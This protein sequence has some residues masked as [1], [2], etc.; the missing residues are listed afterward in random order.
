MNILLV[1]DKKDVLDTMGELLEVCQNHKVQGV[2]SGKEAIRF[3]RKKRYDLV[4]MD[5]MLP[6]MN[7]VEVIS[8]VRKLRSELRIVVLTGIPLNEDLKEKLSKLDVHRIFVK[9]K[10]IHDL[11]LYIKDFNADHIAASA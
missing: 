9:P 3:I 4:I 6:H 1:D 5:L 11:L 10:G 2:S 8:K 7:G